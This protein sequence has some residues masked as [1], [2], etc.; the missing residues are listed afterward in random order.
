[1]DLPDP[2]RLLSIWEHG[3][4]RHPLDRAVLLLSL[5]EPRRAPETLADV[6]LGTRNAA[7][8]ALRQ[9]CFDA[10]LEA[11][12]DCPRCAQRMSL[13]LGPDDLPPPPADDAAPVEVHGHRFRRPG[14]RHLAALAHIDSPAEAARALMR[15]CA[16]Q[17]ERLPGDPAALAAL[18]AELEDALDQADPWADLAL[19]MHCPACGAATEASF[20]VAA[21]LWEELDAHAHQLLDDVHALAGAYGWSER[22]ILALSPQRRAAYLARVRT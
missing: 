10:P 5:A 3:A 1:M 22:E 15:S 20:D 18:Q 12:L 9:A 2:G 6:P 7:L 4:R 16:E 13:A 8:L 11:W 21:F 14:T 19:Q 17:P